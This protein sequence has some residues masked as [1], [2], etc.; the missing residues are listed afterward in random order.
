[1]TTPP[2]PLRQFIIAAHFDLAAVQAALAAHPDWLD[3]AYDWGAEGGTETALGAAAHV[4]NR[5]I[6]RYL[7]AEGAT[8]TPAAA[9]MLGDRAALDALIDLDPDNANA[10]GAH[11]IPLLAHA[12]FQPDPDLLDHLLARGT[13]P[14]GLGLVLL[15][16]ATA[17]HAEVVRWALAHGADPTTRNYQGK[18]AAEIAQQAGFDHVLDALA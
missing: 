2:D 11:G 13:R 17:G 8:I 7:L 18:T 16:A 9:A 4:G 5:P 12:A 3:I 1:M 15:N 14:E 10:A 6:A